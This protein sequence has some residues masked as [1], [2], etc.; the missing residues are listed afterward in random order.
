[1]RIPELLPDLPEPAA[2]MEVGGYPPERH[3]VLAYMG[4]LNTPVSREGMMRRLNIVARMLSDDT[5]PGLHFPWH[6]LTYVQLLAV[7]AKL[8]QGYAPQTCNVTLYAVKGVLKECWRLGYLTAE[9]HLRASDVPPVKGVRLPTGRALEGSELTQLFYSCQH[10]RRPVLG[11]RD[12]A[13]IGLLYGLGLRSS[14]AIGLNLVDYEPMAG[15]VRVLG[16][17]NHER[18]LPLPLAV[19][20]VMQSWLAHR[21]AWSGPLLAPVN[22]EHVQHRRLDRRSINVILKNR[23]ERAGVAHFSPHD[24]RRTFISNLLDATGDLSTVQALA[25][26]SDPKITAGYDR[27]GMRA[28]HAAMGQLMFPRTT[29]E[30]SP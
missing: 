10:D 16:K 4:R 3:P 17:G 12:A 26:H 27:R 28:K 7:R 2:V 24:C 9:E 25:G 6:R 14:E 1:M 13:A 15:T 5:L 8:T 29:Q 20:E 21:G 22:S 19:V 18:E 30:G 11:A 23:R